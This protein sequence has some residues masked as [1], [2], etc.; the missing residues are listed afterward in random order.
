M[1]NGMRGLESQACAW[2]AAAIGKELI[3]KPFVLLCLVQAG[4]GSLELT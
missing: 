1:V 2:E 4:A 3:I